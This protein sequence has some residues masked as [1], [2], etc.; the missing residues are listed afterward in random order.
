MY[1]LQSAQNS[2]VTVSQ[3][4]LLPACATDDLKTACTLDDGAQLLHLGSAELT[5]CTSTLSMARDVIAGQQ[6]LDF[7]SAELTQC[8]GLAP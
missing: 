6:L 4:K 8:I 3:G 1:I 2:A 5:Q 7:S